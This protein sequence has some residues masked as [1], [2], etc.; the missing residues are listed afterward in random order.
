MQ[1]DT[2][3]MHHTAGMEEQGRDGSAFMLNMAGRQQSHGDAA[4]GAWSKGPPGVQVQVQ[5]DAHED[6]ADC[7]L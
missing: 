5:L 3:T 7:E 1:G 6:D 2:R 4:A